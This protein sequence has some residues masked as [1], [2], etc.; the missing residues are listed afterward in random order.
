MKT[1]QTLAAFSAITFSLVMGSAVAGPDWSTIERGRSTKQAE[2]KKSAGG[3]AS[4][5]RQMLYSN[6]PRAPFSPPYKP[7]DVAKS[8]TERVVTSQATN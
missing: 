6:S 4:S 1:T 8:T 7:L 3:E 2:L 5:S